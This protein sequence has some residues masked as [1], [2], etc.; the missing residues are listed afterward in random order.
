MREAHTV[1]GTARVMGFNAIAEAGA[2]LESDWTA[3]MEHQLEATAELGRHFL[4][5]SQN[6]LPAV[7]AHPDEGTPELSA[8]LR[9]LIAGDPPAS[10]GSPSEAPP[11]EHDTDAGEPSPA[12][13]EMATHQYA[14]DQDKPDLTVI[15][16]SKGDG[17]PIDPNAGQPRRLACFAG[18]FCDRRDNSGRNRQVVP[19]D[20]PRRRAPTR[21]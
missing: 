17:P 5:I 8:A 10:V 1:K 9:A 6:L 3:V 14:P 20:Q 2:R 16:G 19:A 21:W 11:I 13:L 15:E 12:G 18:F 7:D 4:D